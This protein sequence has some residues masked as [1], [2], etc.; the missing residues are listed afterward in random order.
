MEFNPINN[1]NNIQI[2]SQKAGLVQNSQQ[3]AQNQAPQQEPAQAQNQINNINKAFIAD[4]STIKM[5]NET[6]LKYLKS[7]LKFPSTIENFTKQLYSKN[8]DPKLAKILTQNMINTKALNEILNQNSTEAISKLMQ[9]ISNSLKTGMSDI[10]QLK[11]VLTILSAIQTSTNINTT[12]ALKELL[13]LYIPFNQQIFD[14]NIDD[15]LISEGE[16]QAIKNSKLSI[17]FETIN[18]SNIVININEDKNNIYLDIFCNKNFA[19]DKFK[20]IITALSKELSINIS[21]DF[22]AK[23]NQENNNKIQNFK[24]ISDGFISGN[25]LIVAHIAIKTIL[26][27]DNDFLEI[28]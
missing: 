16:K 10:E 25:C 7:L 11:E 27:I 9:T 15:K 22:T 4:Y 8:I 17:L 20:T 5:D 28:I 23:F 18:F 2:S 6:I 24:I 1:F 19:R 26:K 13:L 12:N 21:L 14:K 3:Q